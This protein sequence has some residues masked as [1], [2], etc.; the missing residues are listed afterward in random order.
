MVVQTNFRRDHSPYHSTRSTQVAK[1]QHLTHGLNQLP[2][3]QLLTLGIRD[4]NCI[5]TVRQSSDINCPAAGVGYHCSA[6]HATY[7]DKYRI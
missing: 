4:C 5:N 6:I 1:A 2:D 3:L 7:L